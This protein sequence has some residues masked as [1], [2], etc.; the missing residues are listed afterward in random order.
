MRGRRDVEPKEDARSLRSLGGILTAILGFLAWQHHPVAGAVL[1]HVGLLAIGGAVVIGDFM[2]RYRWRGF[3][4]LVL[5]GLLV[6]LDDLLSH[7][8]GVQTPLDG[9]LWMDVLLPI[10]YELRALLG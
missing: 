10:L 4:G 7:A 5:L 6:S 3:R 8:C 2:Q 9:W 1:S